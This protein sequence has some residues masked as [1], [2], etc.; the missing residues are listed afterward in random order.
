MPSYEAVP[1]HTDGV[2]V[3]DISLGNTVINSMGTWVQCVA[4]SGIDCASFWVY[5]LQQGGVVSALM[6]I[7]T[8]AGGAETVLIQEILVQNGSSQLC[9]G[10]ISAKYYADISSSTRIAAQMQNNSVFQALRMAMMLIGDST[11]GLATPTTYGSLAASSHGTQIDPGAVINMKGTYVQ[12]TASSAALHQYVTTIFGNNVNTT[13]QLNIWASDV[14]IGAGGAE[15][16]IIPDIK[17]IADTVAD[18][19]FPAGTF[20][21]VDDIPASTRIAVDSAT[22]TTNATDRLFDVVLICGE[23]PTVV[24]AGGSA[25]VF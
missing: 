20:W 7:G 11:E 6:N 13:P 15:V 3:Y 23:V 9:I 10:T 17:F 4:S 19:I 12:L 21:H 14:S 16:V 8:G 5:P 18:N 25:H 2:G 24:T 1:A 22:N